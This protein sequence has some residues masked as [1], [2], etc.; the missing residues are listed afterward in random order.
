MVVVTV[1]VV[2]VVVCEAAFTFAFAFCLR[3][4]LSLFF[5]SAALT[6]ALEG[7]TADIIDT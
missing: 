1:E 3:S 5:S 6:G 4:R 7:V 2:V